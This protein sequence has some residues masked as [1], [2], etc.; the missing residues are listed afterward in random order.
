ME[1]KTRKSKEKLRRKQKCYEL[2][3]DDDSMQW[4]KEDEE[5]VKKIEGQIKDV[6]AFMDK[7][8]I[9]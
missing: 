4:I 2:Y 5:K 8:G 7:H 1:R 9:K 6:I 3:G